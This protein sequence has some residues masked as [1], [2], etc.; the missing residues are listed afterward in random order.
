MFIKGLKLMGAV[1]LTAVICFLI[2]ILLAKL[3][4]KLFPIGALI[5]FLTTAFVGIKMLIKLKDED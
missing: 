1:F 2:M 5:C 3:V 4:P